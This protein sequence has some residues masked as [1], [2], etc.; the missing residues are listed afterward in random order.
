MLLSILISTS[1]VNDS[2]YCDDQND[3]DNEKY[4]MLTLE[5]SILSESP[6]VSYVGNLSL[7]EFSKRLKATMLLVNQVVLLKLM[8]HDIKN[9]YIYIDIADTF[10]CLDMFALT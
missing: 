7:H 2:N 10:R 1:L 4:S 5:N 6:I 3:D 8:T 9:I